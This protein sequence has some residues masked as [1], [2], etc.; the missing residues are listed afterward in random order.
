MALIEQRGFRFEKSGHYKDQYKHGKLLGQGSHSKVH[1]CQEIR[2]GS[3]V[4]VKI[5]EKRLLKPD[6]QERYMKEIY[7]LKALD[8]PYII[9]VI[10]YF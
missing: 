4:A 5:M 2:T 1:L 3:M 10:E 6:Q 8:N 9:N 7:M